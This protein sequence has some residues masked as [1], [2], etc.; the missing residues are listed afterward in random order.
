MTDDVLSRLAATIAD[1]RSASANVSYTKSLLDKGVSA[2]AKKF[3][4]E[5][6]ETVIAAMSEDDE[7]VRS[8]SA[9]VLYHLLVLL[10]SRG[11]TIGSVLAELAKRQSQSGLAEKAS[12]SKESDAA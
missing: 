11:V 2:C 12:R 10:E 8:E 4:E 6:I 5:A 9:D 3:G 1:R 7:R